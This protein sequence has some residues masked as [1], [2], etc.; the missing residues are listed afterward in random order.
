MVWFK[1]DLRVT[2]HRPLAEAAA[3]CHGGVVGL[4]IYEPIVLNA[5]EHDARH[6]A[7]VNDCLLD[8]RSCM[9]ELGS[10][11]IL[12][13][14]EAVEVLE[15][16]RRVIGF[17]DLFSH[18]ETGLMAT[19]ERDLAIA[20]W[21]SEVGVRWSEF[22][23]HGV[24]RPLRSRDGWAR[25]WNSRMHEPAAEVLSEVPT[26]AGSGASRIAPGEILQPEHPVPASIQRGGSR[27]AVGLLDSFLYRRGRLYQS[28]MSSPIEGADSCSRLS[29]H[30]AYGSISIRTVLQATESR[31]R[32]LQDEC[33]PDTSDWKRSIASFGK[34]LRWHCH[35][36]QKLEDEPA[37]ENQNF[38]RAFDG[39]RTEDHALWSI[40]ERSRFEAF[41]SAQTGYP[42][43]DA[44]LRC[45][46]QTGW[47]NFRMRAMLMSFASYHLWLHWKQPAIHLAR[48]FTDFE[49]GIHYSQCQMQSGVT[50][51]NTVR[52][53]SPL[54]QQIDQDPTGCFVRRWIPELEGVPDEHLATPHAMPSMT[55]HMSGCVIGSHYPAPIVEHQAAYAEAK[56]RVF[57]YRRAP[58][59]E[60]EAERVFWK[61]GSRRS[62]SRRSRW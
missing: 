24:V 33:G 30:L 31:A 12:L 22:P 7:F 48:L 18:E 14:G 28:E 29:P 40:A 46:E 4:Y 3:R 39:M 36:I 13:Q 26:L 59:A 16:L 20:R 51:I 58:A 49:P 60:Q 6:L 1:R 23:Q 43:V 21:A 52:I 42:F 53:Y 2:D 50:G 17:T 32:S 55:Q 35:F 34:R 44:C 11:L 61:H 19:Y 38:S 41:R 62:P 9:N 54:K 57:E 10:E 8:L 27:A 45:L 56:R 47:I 25:R 15:R 5:A 37:I